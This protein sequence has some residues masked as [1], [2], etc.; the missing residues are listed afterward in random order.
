MICP[1]C[2]GRLVSVTTVMIRLA[3][4][5]RSALVAGA[6]ALAYV[7]ACRLAY[8]FRHVLTQIGY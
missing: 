2:V 3:D 4:A 1:N 5:V 7:F 8:M 6:Y